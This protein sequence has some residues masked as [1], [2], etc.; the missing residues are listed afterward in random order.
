MPYLKL[1]GGDLMGGN[2]RGED[3]D[4]RGELMFVRVFFALGIRSG[5][6][7][8]KYPIEYLLYLEFL[9]L[10]RVFP[11]DVLWFKT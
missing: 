1:F 9:L 2:E 8:T 7:L 11:L 10:L 3:E 6:S 5:L 4:Y